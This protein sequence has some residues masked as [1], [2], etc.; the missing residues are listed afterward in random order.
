MRIFFVAFVMLTYELRLSVPTSKP[1]SF[2]SE[3]YEEWDFCPLRNSN[4]PEKRERERKKS[5]ASLFPPFI[6]LTEPA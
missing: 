1:V 2:S 5:V 4:D 6:S 3:G